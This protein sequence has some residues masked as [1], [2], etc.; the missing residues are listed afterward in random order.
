M[1][2]RHFL[3]RGSW[4]RQLIC[5]NSVFRGRR[6]CMMSLQ[7]PVRRE[8]ERFNV[9]EAIWM[10]PRTARYLTHP[11]AAFLRARSLTFAMP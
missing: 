9:D 2:W 5:R 6:I 3:R 1:C 10:L 8:E 7:A 11:A 4:R